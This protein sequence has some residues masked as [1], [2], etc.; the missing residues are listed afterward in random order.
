MDGVPRYPWDRV[1]ET[2]EATLSPEDERAQLLAALREKDEV[3]TSLLRQIQFLRRELER[4]ARRQ[5]SGQV[6]S[7]SRTSR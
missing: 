1:T 5:V 7:H 3:I 2:A 4:A 6:A